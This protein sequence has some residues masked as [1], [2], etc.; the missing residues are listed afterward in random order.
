MLHTCVIGIIGTSLENNL[1]S[2]SGIIID[3]A[4]MLH[5]SCNEAVDRML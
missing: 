3:E 4:V 5:K 2:W 1:R